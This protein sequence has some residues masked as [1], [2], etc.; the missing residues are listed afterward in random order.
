MLQT[1][2]GICK[3]CRFILLYLQ[4]VIILSYWNIREGNKKK[5]NDFSCC[6][7]IPKI[8]KGSVHNLIILLLWV[9]LPYPFIFYACFLFLS[10]YMY[11]F[12]LRK[13]NKTVVFLFCWF[14]K[15]DGS[16][17]GCLCVFFKETL[18]YYSFSISYFRGRKVLLEN[19]CL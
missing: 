6:L 10:V 15:K 13:E 9:L 17:L 4:C 7:L 11:L 19:L 8:V 18:F 1:K 16:A 12:S 3:R 2:K 5:W 14:L